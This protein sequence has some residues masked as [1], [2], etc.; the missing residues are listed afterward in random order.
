M[1]D[2][3]VR[4]NRTAV[5]HL[6]R[7]ERGSVVGHNPHLPGLPVHL[8]GGDDEGVVD[9]GVFPFYL[10]GKDDVHYPDLRD[11]VGGLIEDVTLNGVRRF[12][13]IFVT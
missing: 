4:A 13:F 6:S 11:S 10:P 7:E 12:F 8:G 9:D 3:R 5:E 2:R 1:F